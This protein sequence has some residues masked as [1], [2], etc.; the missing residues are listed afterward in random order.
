MRRLSRL[1][2]VVQIG[3]LGCW[4]SVRNCVFLDFE[5]LRSQNR[6]GFYPFACFLPFSGSYA[7]ALGFCRFTYFFTYVLPPARGQPCVFFSVPGEQNTRARDRRG[8]PVQRQLEH[9]C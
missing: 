3:F 2:S 4:M 1:R 8:L 5:L 9:T 7:A 6:A